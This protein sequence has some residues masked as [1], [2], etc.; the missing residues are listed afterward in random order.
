MLT[1]EHNWAHRV[2]Q[3]NVKIAMMVSEIGRSQTAWFMY[4]NRNQLKKAH[5]CFVRL[6]IYYINF[7]DLYQNHP[8]LIIFSVFNC[9]NF[10]TDVLSFAFASLRCL[11]C[12]CVRLFNFNLSGFK[13]RTC[14]LIK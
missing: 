9:I 14:L 13:R 6:K 1:S 7:G 11:F 3:K 12:I 8:N 10:W 4:R 5:A 2:A